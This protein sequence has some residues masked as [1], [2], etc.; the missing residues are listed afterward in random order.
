MIQLKDFQKQ[1][2]GCT[3]KM[4][5]KPLKSVSDETCPFTGRTTSQTF[6]SCTHID[7]RVSVYLCPNPL[8]L[9]PFF[10]TISEPSRQD[11]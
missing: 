2:M 10:W 5:E 6:L 1:S 8:F 7:N 3:L 9:R 4:L 11:R